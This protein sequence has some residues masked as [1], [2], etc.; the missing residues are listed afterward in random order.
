MEHRAW[1]GGRQR[2]CPAEEEQDRPHGGE[3]PAGNE[4]ADR[5]RRHRA[6][7]EDRGDAGQR[8]DRQIGDDADRRDLVEVRQG[9][10]QHRELSRRAHGERGGDRLAR[11]RGQHDAGGGREGELEARIVEVGGTQG[12]DDERGQRQAVQHG[13][14]TLEQQRGEDED[15]HDRGAQ[16][17]GLR[18]DDHGKAE[19]DGQRAERGEAAGDARQRQHR[20]R[21]RGDQRD[22][23]ARH[24]QHVIDARAPERGIDLR[25]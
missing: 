20:P 21:R 14:F 16:H 6:E 3:E 18:P 11:H 8:H 12:E 17:R 1:N 25:R 4:R 13:G 15:G 7:T 9:D 5:R 24:R 23:E 2:H 19:D 10:R 22:V